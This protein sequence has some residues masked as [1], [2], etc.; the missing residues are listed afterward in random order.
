MRIGWVGGLK[1]SGTYLARIAAEAGC[2]LE[3][4]NGNVRGRGADGLANLV[5]RSSCVIILT[6][7]NSHMGVQL[8][9]QMALRQ[10]RPVFVMQRCGPHTF[11]RL[12]D[13][14]Q[15]ISRTDLKIKI[16]E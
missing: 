5:E 7:I 8:A 15:I 14:I 16:G 6:T 9:K 13:T 2:E 12:L 3:Y 4:H 11:R 10:K 1:R